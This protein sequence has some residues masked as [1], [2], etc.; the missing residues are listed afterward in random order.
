MSPR[1]LPLMLGQQPVAVEDADALGALPNTEPAA[2]D[3][4]A[5]A[6]EEPT[7]EEPTQEADPFSD[8]SREPLRR[9]G[10]DTGS[11]AT[12]GTSTSMPTVA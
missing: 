9:G 12:V 5:P 4:P 1:L 6:A 8:A 11:Y 3:A 7:A 2:D 10:D